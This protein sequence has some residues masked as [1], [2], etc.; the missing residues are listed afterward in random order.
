MTRPRPLERQA[1]TSQAM[2][3]LAARSQLRADAPAFVPG[4]PQ[5]P[6]ELAGDRLIRELADRMPLGSFP[7]EEPPCLGLRQRSPGRA[8]K[9]PQPGLA[10][11]P[12]EL[13]QRSAEDGSLHE[14]QSAGAT[15]PAAG[16]F[17]PYCASRSSCAFHAPIKSASWNLAG[18]Y[19]DR[20][21]GLMATLDGI[22][23]SAC[24]SELCDS[25]RTQSDDEWAEQAQPLRPAPLYQPHPQ[26][27]SLPDQLEGGD[28]LLQGDPLP[29]PPLYPPPPPPAKPVTK[30]QGSDASVPSRTQPWPTNGV[31]PSAGIAAASR[32]LAVAADQT[33]CT[34]T[35]DGNS[36][37]S[38]T[39][40][41][42]RD[43]SSEVA[44]SSATD[45]GEPHAAS[46]WELS[47]CE[48]AAAVRSASRCQARRWNVLPSR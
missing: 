3:R 6:R 5:R 1:S 13:E 40:D 31:L 9:A 44:P 14:D 29:P 28:E 18:S 16:V 23:P 27:M 11:Q 10:E 22:K 33:P 20:Q 35:S 26:D 12:G 41:S 4:V 42:P 15:L 48:A 39:V 47:K 17:C 25:T 37:R 7:A 21:L 34:E 32:W 38:H 2:A 45:P 24:S 30:Q 46:V 36:P 8:Q 19:P 43:S